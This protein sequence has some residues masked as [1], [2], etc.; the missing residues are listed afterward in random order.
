MSRPV[1]HAASRPAVEAR[2][3]F[4]RMLDEDAG[5]DD[6]AAWTQW[7]ESD[8]R[9]RLAYEEVSDL[10]QLAGQAVKPVAEAPALRADEYDPRSSVSAWRRRKPRLRLIVGA[11]VAVAAV[12]VAVVALPPLWRQQLDE[13][14]QFATRQG[15]HIQA[16][17]AD[18]SAIQLGAATA[19]QVQYGARRRDIGLP[20]GEALFKVA[21]DLKRPFVVT[22]PLGA[23]TA[24]GTAFNVDVRTDSVVLYVAEGVVSVAPAVDGVAAHG[25]PLRITAG[26]QLKMRFADGRVHAEQDV[27]APPPAWQEGRLEYRNESLALVLEDVNRYARRPIIITDQQIGELRYTGTV[28]LDATDA[29]AFGLAAAFP[30]SVRQ[31]QDGLLLE[32]RSEKPAAQPKGT[33]T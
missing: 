22:T 20:R 8:P 32:R 29:W 28:R 27:S 33:A 17:L 15:E 26:E 16:H 18:G 9:N 12:A 4:V 5:Q 10:W 2:E 30:L 11:A 7:L 24:V 21:H 6:F 1:R 14:Q 23:I 25:S 3:W 19:L 13:A 31:D